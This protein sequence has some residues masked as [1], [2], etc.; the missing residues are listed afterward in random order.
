MK[1]FI[2][3]DEL[4]EWMNIDF[5]HAFR[6]GANCVFAEMGGDRQRQSVVVKELKDKDEAV[7]FLNDLLCK[8]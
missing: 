2:Y 4:R 3:I 8:S 7:K 6:I 1:R 5:I